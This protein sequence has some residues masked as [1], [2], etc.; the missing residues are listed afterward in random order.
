MLTQVTYRFFKQNRIKGLTGFQ[1]D[2][3]T[4]VAWVRNLLLRKPVLDR[5]QRDRV[6]QPFLL[7][8]GRE[9]RAKKR[10]QLG[11]RW[12]REHFRRRQLGT[13]AVDFRGHM[14]GQDRV[15]T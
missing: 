1:S 14:Y 11:D 7:G 5:R 12:M 6:I 8:D 2:R 4:R 10:R 9:V 3:L 15:P 13:D